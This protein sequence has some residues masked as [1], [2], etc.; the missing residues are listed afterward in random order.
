[1]AKIELPEGQD[2]VRLA[3]AGHMVRLMGAETAN[4]H[5]GSRNPEDL[6]Q[7]L[8]RLE[9]R[10]GKNWLIEAT[11]AMTACTESDHAA[12]EKHFGKP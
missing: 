6:K 2:D 7:R 10:V 9:Q 4:I 1:V 12:W 8:L 5:L 11:E 3:L